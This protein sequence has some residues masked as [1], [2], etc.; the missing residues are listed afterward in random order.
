MEPAVKFE[1]RINQGEGLDIVLD[2]AMS[3]G[4]CFAITAQWAFLLLKGISYETEIITCQTFMKTKREGDVKKMIEGTTNVSVQK[5]FFTLVSLQR[6]YDTLDLF[7]ADKM[8]AGQQDAFFSKAATF[9]EKYLASL[10]RSEGCKLQSMDLFKTV[11]EVTDSLSFDDDSVELIGIFGT[12]TGKNWGHIVGAA[13]SAKYLF[14]DANSG[15]KSGQPNVMASQISS[16][17]KSNYQGIQNCVKYTI[18][19]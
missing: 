11:D 18:T 5:G 8:D 16:Y 12:E 17:L 6:G 15:L 3:G 14:F 2:K 4:I 19:K 9:S 1:L 13:K 10:C 7:L